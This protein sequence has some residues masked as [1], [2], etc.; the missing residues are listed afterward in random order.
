APPPAPPPAPP[1]APP[2]APPPAPPVPTPPPTRGGAGRWI[3]LAA[4]VVLI[5]AGA[6]L[7]FAL[8]RPGGDPDRAGGD[9]K[10]AR[11]AAA[12][13]GDLDGD[14][15]GD[16]VWIV[17]LTYDQAEQMTGTSDG[18][19]FTTKGL[20]VE[21]YGDAH[22][23]WFDW[24]ADGRN[25]PLTWTYDDDT[26]R[27]ALTSTDPDFPGD[28]S[29]ALDL[30]SLRDYGLDVQVVSGDFDGDGDLDLAVAGPD[31]KVVAIAVLRNDGTG[32]F[33]DPERW[34][35]LPNATID[36]TTLHAGDFDDDGDAD[37]W[38]QLPSERLDADDYSGYYSGAGGQA[39]LT[40]T[41]T[42][43]EE[44]A[45]SVPRDRADAYLV[46]DVVGD[47]SVRLVG[48]TADTYRETLKVTVYDVST[49]SLEA[50]TGFTGQSRVGKRALQGATL[51][52]V[53]G[54]GKADVVFVVKGYDESAFGG[55]QV[56]RSTG[57]VYEP[58]TQWA[59]TPAC[60]EDTCRIVF[61]DTAA[62]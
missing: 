57:S 61:P 33:A 41:G 21:P 4:V 15:Y 17:N 18:K 13:Q 9:H 53:D 5:V 8:L 16:A 56:M 50:V 39:L 6:G 55:V 3:A 32:R 10:Q 36:S 54:D 1:S 23:V 42:A 48:V 35:S 38:A 52:D 46:G 45:V 43:F 12:V 34:L 47:G 19:V 20:T 11:P 60:P 51:S 58:A 40:S 24:D 37:L 25:E 30:S 27:L 14:G 29:M 44:G 62:N 49:G 22:Q 26:D 2:P 28:Q 59:A 31:D 7:A